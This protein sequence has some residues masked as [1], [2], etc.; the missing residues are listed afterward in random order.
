MVVLGGFL[1]WFALSITLWIGVDTPN[2]YDQPIQRPTDYHSSEKK[3]L[4]EAKKTH[5]K[6]PGNSHAI[7]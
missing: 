5:Y 7:R 6:E 1:G 3:L 4:G 2:S